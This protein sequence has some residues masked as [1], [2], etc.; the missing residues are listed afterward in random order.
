[1]ND[2]KRNA[3]AAVLSVAVTGLAGCGAAAVGAAGGA[4][5]AAG[6]EYEDR[7]AQSHVSADVATVAAAAE[8]ALRDLGITLEERQ[9]EADENEVE[10]KGED[11][12]RKVVVDVE[13]GRD[14]GRIH[15]EV[16]V[17]KN[18]VEYD[19]SRAD[20]ILRAILARLPG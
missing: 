11:G 16:T 8:V 4:G 18:A 15:V 12:S 14:A 6:M 9:S 10:L 1:M 13:G 20:E 5:A 7:G 3:I 19:K 2:W 17:S